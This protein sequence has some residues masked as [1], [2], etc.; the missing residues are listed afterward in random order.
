MEPAGTKSQTRDRWLIFL[1]LGILVVTLAAVILTAPRDSAPTSAKAQ[2]SL[3]IRSFSIPSSSMEP[4]LRVGERAFADMQAY[5]AQAPARGDIVVFTLP[6][7]GS[8]TYVKRIIGLPG[9][10][11]QMKGGIVQIN[12]RA[13]PT[14]D[15]GTYKLALPGEPEKQVPLKRETL[16]NGVSVTTLDLLSNGFYDN[17]SVFEV[18]AGQYFV[19]GDN[20]DNSTDSRVLDKFGYIPRANVIGRITLIF[21]SSDFSRIGTMPK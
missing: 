11:V 8:P 4:A 5:D 1:G 19:L 6:G 2:R 13:V 16:P 14:V 18:P 12:G 21:W 7:D 3:P 15:A 17:T 9:E 20:R 10:K